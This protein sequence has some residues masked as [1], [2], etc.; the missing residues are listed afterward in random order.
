LQRQKRDQYDD[1]R[2]GDTVLQP[3]DEGGSLHGKSGLENSP[4]LPH[5]HRETRPKNVKSG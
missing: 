4:I 5:A 1:R 3:G 2:V